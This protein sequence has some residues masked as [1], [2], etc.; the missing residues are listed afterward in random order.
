MWKW[1]S[2]YDNW[3]INSSWKVPTEIWR[4]QSLD[5][6]APLTYVTCIGLSYALPKNLSHLEK[7]YIER[8]KHFIEF[9]EYECKCKNSQQSISKSKVI[10]YK[11]YHMP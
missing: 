5:S 11:N 4:D 10:I 2:M 9:Q 3:V 6:K 7:I 1:N 8:H